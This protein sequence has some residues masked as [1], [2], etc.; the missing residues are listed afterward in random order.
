[1]DLEFPDPP[2]PFAPAGTEVVELD[3]RYLIPGLID[4]HQQLATRAG[5]SSAPSSWWATAPSSR[6]ARR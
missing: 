3:G 6:R 1:M 5:A 4:S 2:A